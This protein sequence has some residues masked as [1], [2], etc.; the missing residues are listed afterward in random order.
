MWA[1]KC[2]VARRLGMVGQDP[3]RS[4]RAMP[5]HGSS[6]SFGC[7]R[8]SGDTEPGICRHWLATNNPEEVARVPREARDPKATLTYPYG[9]IYK[10]LQYK[11][12][13]LFWFSVK[14]T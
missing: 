1:W 9:K 10:K 14:K 13:T 11:W 5:N 7:W 8:Y 2:I 4:G 12:N 6:L 3:S